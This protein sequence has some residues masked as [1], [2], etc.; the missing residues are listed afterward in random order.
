VSL[1]H[2]NTTPFE[3]P[4]GSML[5]TAASDG[6][7]P[8]ETPWTFWFD[9]R[10][11]QP[12]RAGE[13][14]A[15]E[16]NLFKIGEVQTVEEFWRYFGNLHAPSKL[17]NNSNYHFFKS[18]IKPLWEDPNNKNGGKWIINIKN[19]DELLD[20][21]WENVV[22][23]LIGETLEAGS[24]VCGAVLS[25]RRSGDKIAVWNGTQDDAT[26]IGEKLK[27]LIGGEEKG[28]MIYYQTHEN[29]MRTGASYYNPD[30]FAL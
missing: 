28:F 6:S 2:A 13:K 21:C 22:L 1:A 7:H 18:H 15:Y 11:S 3:G 27:D 26:V 14:E 12:R 29:C 19:D 20:K 16:S 17:M 9:C 4:A 10:S 8:L 25:R 30:K 23:A 5:E 24:D